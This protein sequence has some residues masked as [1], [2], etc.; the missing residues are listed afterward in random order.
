MPV[1]PSDLRVNRPEGSGFRPGANARFLVLHR[2]RGAA[3]FA[4]AESFSASVAFCMASDPRYASFDFEMYRRTFR[5][6]AKMNMLM[7]AAGIKVDWDRGL[8]QRTAT[9]RRRTS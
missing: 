7:E 2:R 4:A 8:F 6:D 9:M 1:P 3:I 5:F